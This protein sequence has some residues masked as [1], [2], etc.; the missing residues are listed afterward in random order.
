MHDIPIGVRPA[1]TK[2]V[3]PTMRH[4]VPLALLVLIPATA[5]AEPPLA[6]PPSAQVAPVELRRVA[7]GVTLEVLSPVGGAGCF[8]RRRWLVGALVT[9]GSLIGG[10]L[11]LHG[12]V[13]GNSDEVGLNAFAYGVSRLVGIVAT[14]RPDPLP[15]PPA[16]RAPVVGFSYGASF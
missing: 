16:P 8:Y 10:G 5:H 11:M 2:R 12:L 6:S 7:L 4:L 13:R 9:A 14:A 3:L 1:A 15:L